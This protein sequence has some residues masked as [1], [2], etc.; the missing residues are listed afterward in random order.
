VN[1]LICFFT[2]LKDLGALSLR[3]DLSR[4]LIF[5]N[6]S[7]DMQATL[8]ERTNQL[9]NE[10]EVLSLKGVRIASFCYLLHSLYLTLAV[11]I[12]PSFMF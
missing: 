7:C 6:T 8:V 12:A 9:L 5:K 10:K 2:L 4:H 3:N 1:N 11:P